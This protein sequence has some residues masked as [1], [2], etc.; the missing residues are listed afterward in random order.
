M[1][2]N[3]FAG[4][5]DGFFVDVGANDPVRHNNTLFFEEQGWSGIA[6][7]PLP[8]M[9][10]RWR[11]SARKARFFPVAASNTRGTCTLEVVHGK[12]DWQ[13]MLSGIR[14]SRRPSGEYDAQEVTVRAECVRDILSAE[15]IGVVDYLSIDV[16]GHELSVLEGIDFQHVEFR[17]ITIENNAGG[18]HRFGDPRIRQLLK[19]EGFRY[20]AR[21]EGLDDI[22][23][24]NRKRWRDE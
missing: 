20:Y 12:K 11:R 9:E 1:Y 5:T 2:S 14:G 4:R 10:E 23:V 19:S 6:I 16:E 21:I 3:F 24:N 17:V 13:T 7:D 18:S 15:G 22:Y 8:G